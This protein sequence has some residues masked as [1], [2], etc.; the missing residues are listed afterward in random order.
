M[1]YYREDQIAENNKVQQAI[2]S[3]ML[4]YFFYRGIDLWYFIDD[5][6]ECTDDDLEDDEIPFP[7]TCKGQSQGD[8]WNDIDEGKTY[9][10]QTQD[11]LEYT[12][13]DGVE[14]EVWRHMVTKEEYRVPTQ[15]VRDFDNMTKI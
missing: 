13:G 2:P 5:Y 6:E 3:N 7:M 15:I 14:Y 11:F 4:E 9:Y 1:I 8:K 10:A 12:D